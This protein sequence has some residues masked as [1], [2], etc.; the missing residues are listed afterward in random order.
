MLNRNEM[1]SMMK[2]RNKRKDKEA[3]EQFYTWYNTLTPDDKRQF[4]KFCRKSTYISIAAVV[5]IFGLIGSCMFG[6]GKNSSP[7]PTTSI[8][9]D[10]QSAAPPSPSASPTVVNPLT[11]FGIRPEDFQREANQFLKDTA[12]QIHMNID[13]WNISRGSANDVYRYNFS[14]ANALICGV[15]KSNNK[16]KN[17]MFITVPKTQTDMLNAI[18]YYGTI[19]AILNPELDADES[20]VVIRELGLLG[21]GADILNLNGKVARG[22]ILYS[23]TSSKEMGIV[24]GADVNRDK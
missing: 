8:P 4:D 3:Q 24:F 12:P 20:G 17:I 15:D 6:G 19:I 22:S 13:R 10:T 5:I 18:A 21:E 14:S 2:L 9:R 11:T 7:T 23:L 16:I 1:H